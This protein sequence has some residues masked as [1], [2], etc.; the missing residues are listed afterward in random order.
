[1]NEEK[2]LN[3]RAATPME[4]L[5]LYSQSSQI[6]AQTGLI[7]YLRADMDKG[8]E[9]F[10]TTW[11]EQN[12]DL[13]TDEFSDEIDEVINACR[14][15]PEYGGMLTDRTKMTQYCR[16]HSEGKFD[17]N[18]TTEYGFR[19][20][21]EQY[22]YLMRLNPTKGDYDLYCYCYKREWLDNHLHRA[23]KGIRFITPDYNE[24]FRV[25]DGD[26]IRIVTEDGEIRDRTVRYVDDYHIEMHGEHGTT[27]YHICEFAERMEKSN[28]QKVIPL[29]NSLP[30]S[31][32]SILPD[33]KELII[34]NRGESGYYR[35]D[36]SEP[37]DNRALADELNARGGVSKAQEEAMRIGSMFGWEV[38]GA[39]PKNYD[40]NGVPLKIKNRDRGDAR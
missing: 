37:G 8:G 35:C 40:E 13:H 3:I 14:Y 30:I 4:R 23:E 28:A 1:M 22:A 33:T 11:F 19:V 6:G 32:Y 16:E 10:Y 21:T 2:S 34:I 29:R 25:A 36:F 38:P 20:D 15:E 5:Y 9:G 27:L 39:D 17:G 7:G 18:Y 26:K 24:L 31:C 12:N